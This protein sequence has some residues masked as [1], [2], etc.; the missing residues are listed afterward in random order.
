MVEPTACAVHAA[1]LVDADGSSSSCSAPARSGC[2]PS[3]PCAAFAR[4][5][6]DPRHRQAPAPARPGHARS[7]PTRW[8]RR[9]SS[10]GLVRRAPGRCGWTSASSPA[11]PQPSSTASASP[12]SLAAGSADRGPRRHASTLVGMPGVTTV[13]LT[14]LWQREIS[15]RAAYAYQR[16]DFDPALDLVARPR[17]RPAG[18][19]HL[20]PAPLHGRHR[21]RRR[22]RLPRRRQDRLR[23]PVGTRE[24]PLLMPR[25]GFVL[26]VD[27]S[28]PPILFHHGERSA[29]RS[30]PPAAVGSSTRPSRSRRSTTPTA[31]SATRC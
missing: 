30:C 10:T 26:D 17:P 27:R 23:P 21:P 7:A 2:S 20:S 6:D 31:P 14:P 16:A 29:S 28:T 18:Q 11:A 5:A 12:D 4:P 22:R 1:S 19:R 15:L 9:A 24:R 25:P 3:P 8:S 13:D